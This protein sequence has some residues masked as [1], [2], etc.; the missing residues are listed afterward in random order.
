[1]TIFRPSRPKGLPGLGEKL[2]VN[3]RPEDFD[4]DGPSTTPY[5]LPKIK[6]ESSEQEDELY[7]VWSRHGYDVYTTK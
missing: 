2:E 6:D 7:K 4:T 5:R 3:F 1:M